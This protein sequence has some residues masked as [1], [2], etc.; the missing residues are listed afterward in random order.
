MKHYLAFALVLGAC[1]DDAI[2]CKGRPFVTR[3]AIVPVATL[4]LSLDG[5]VVPVVRDV[6]VRT[7]TCLPPATGEGGATR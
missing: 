1:N 2:P 6:E 3:T 4:T 5:K 7:R